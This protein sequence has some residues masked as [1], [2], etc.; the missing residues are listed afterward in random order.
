[1]TVYPLDVEAEQVVRWLMDQQAS[2]GHD[3]EIR[4]S[5]AYTMVENARE[6]EPT[7]GD[8]EKEDL[9]EVTVTGTLE[10]VPRHHP[11]GWVLRM[12]VE[13]ELAPRS[14]D[15]DELP[16]GEEEIDL[17]AFNELFVLPQT[18]TSFVEAEAGTP[19]DW[20]RFQV[21]LAEILTNRH[22]A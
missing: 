17:A 2:N 12:R 20:E 19:E 22:A 4:A 3:L 7:L 21:L 8:E 16:E 15:D 5:R 11:D 10:V 14:L 1:M 18:G 9:T 13:D 6:Q